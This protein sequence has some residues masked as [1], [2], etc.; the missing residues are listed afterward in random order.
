LKSINIHDKFDFIVGREDVRKWKPNPE[1]LL[2]IQQHY[3]CKKEEMIY[4][5][6]MQ[7]DLQAG[8]NAGVD[9]YIIG[10]LIDLVNEKR[11]EI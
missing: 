11:W 6:D 9:T 4:F 3:N 5:G 10:D 1:G 7:K 8:Q 2:L